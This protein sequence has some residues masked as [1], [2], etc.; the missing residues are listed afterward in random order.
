MYH[1]S[2]ILYPIS[3][4]LYPIP[5]IIYPISCIINPS[6][7]PVKL[8][9]HAQAWWG[10]CGMSLAGVASLSVSLWVLRLRE[11]GAHGDAHD[12]ACQPDT[13]EHHPATARGTRV[14][15]CRAHDCWW[16]RCKR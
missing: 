8:L 10:A 16:D 7:S 5:Y 12:A 11:R 13:S 2:C 15:E 4:I 3:Y 1:V 9:R 6:P 14:C